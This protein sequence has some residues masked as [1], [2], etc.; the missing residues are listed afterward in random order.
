MT[1]KAH[2]NFISPN[3]RLQLIGLI[4]LARRAMKQIN[5]CER[6]MGGIVGAGESSF[7]DPD[8][9][10]QLADAI[11]QEGEPNVDEILSNMKIEIK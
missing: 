7:V 4:T 9:C 8:Y 10:G 2:V 11:F 3:Q 1:P 5:E 6:A